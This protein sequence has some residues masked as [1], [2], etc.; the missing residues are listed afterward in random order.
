MTLAITVANDASDI[1]LC[2]K[3][4]WAVFVEE[5]GVDPAEEA[6]GEDDH[7]THVLARVA[8]EPVG[9][10]RYQYKADFAKIQR[11]CVLSQMRGTGAG[12]ALMRFILHRLQEEGRA[13]RARLGAQTQAI[14]F[15]RALGFTPVG[16]PYLDAGIPHMDMVRDL[17]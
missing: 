3:L 2:M 13:S 11:V 8:G 9:A 15:Y 7:C 1:A 14:D 12:A 10:A 17:V 5:Q 6:D 16:A 4:R